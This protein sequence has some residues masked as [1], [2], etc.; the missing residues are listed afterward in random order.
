MHYVALQQLAAVLP[1][2]A[3]AIV[4]DNPADSLAAGA[5]HFVALPERPAAGDWCIYHDAQGTPHTAIYTP[6]MKHGAGARKI[7]S[8]LRRP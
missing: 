2:A 7:V 3:T 4:S 6:G 5:T 1:T 8:F